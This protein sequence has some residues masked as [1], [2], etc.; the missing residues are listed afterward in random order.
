MKSCPVALYFN[1]DFQLI[2]QLNILNL[3]ILIFKSPFSLIIYQQFFNNIKIMEKKYS[4]TIRE[5]LYLKYIKMKI[6]I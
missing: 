2:S 1:N 6:N 5:Q 4:Q 3:N